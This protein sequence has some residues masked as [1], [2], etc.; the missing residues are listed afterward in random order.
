[1]K[2]KH[3]IDGISKCMAVLIFST[4]VITACS[5]GDGGDEEQAPQLTL[6]TSTDSPL[7]QSPHIS[8]SQY[9]KNGLY[10]VNVQQRESSSD[11]SGDVAA[12]APEFS[13][14]TTQIDGVDEA[15]RIE[16]DGEYFYVANLPTW[17]SQSGIENRVRILK[18]QNDFSLDVIAD[19]PLESEQEMAGM[20][21]HDKRLGVITRKF[22]YYPLEDAVATSSPWHS[23]DN[24]TQIE[25][26]D[27]TLPN[28]P[29]TPHKVKIDGRL[30]SSRRIGNDLYLA[31]QYVPFADNL[32]AVDDTTS[33]RIKYYQH[34][35]ALDNASL[36]PHITINEQSS[37]LYDLDS[38]L[39]PENASNKNG[40]V[41]MLSV[42]KIDMSSP[43]TYSAL[44]TIVEAH[45]LFM[46]HNNMYLHATQGNGTVFHKVSLDNGIEYQATG[47]VQGIFGW[48]SS[49][50]L[51][52]SERDDYFMAL[53]TQGLLADDPE[54][55]LHVLK[56][57][58]RQLVEVTTLPNDNEPSPIGKPGEDVYAVRFFDDKAYVVTF[59]Q[60]DP[61][62]VID[63]SDVEAPFIRGELTIPGFSSYLHPME[64]GLLLGIGQQVIGAN[65]PSAGEQPMTTPVEDGM[66]VSLFD[67]VD[68][69][70]P[71]LLNEYVWPDTYT[72]AEYDYRALSVLKT[73]TGYRFALPSEAWI[74]D[75]GIFSI[76]Y[77]LQMLAVDSE[78]RT[79]SLVGSITQPQDND[80][81]YGSYDDRSV[82]HGDHV[83]YLRG[84]N[85]YHSL[86]QQ[87]PVIDGPY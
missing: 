86:W 82:L 75:E 25:F 71:I 87:E 1:M 3:G 18:R 8:A 63:L 74:S 81:Y 47:K 73:P 24:D 51:K 46:T 57:Q 7:G 34:L 26:I 44:C 17:D 13:T 53:T 21:L 45:G 85:I 32:P 76:H 5:S 50:Q 56:Q 79:L 27:V 60:I 42:V 28:A 30:I 72:G 58:G 49:A 52:M 64:N 84:N 10:L 12:E 69:E 23:P 54:H 20:Y 33:S 59:E 38:C 80:N 36:V 29:T 77:A 43:S 66:K 4:C 78:E 11:G 65:I 31:M 14:T 40:H 22:G 41:Q 37:P 6:T 15:D 19:I 48:S 62:Y 35:L 2:S 61:L 55:Y 39:V 68:P 9:V 67:V 70:N 16:Y 83:Y